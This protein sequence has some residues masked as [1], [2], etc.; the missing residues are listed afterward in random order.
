MIHG[1]HFNNLRGDVCGGLTAAVVAQPLALAFGVVSGAGPVA[2]TLAKLG[3]DRHLPDGHHHVSR[4]DALRQTAA[5]IA[6]NGAP[7]G[8]GDDWTA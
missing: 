5:T 1:I 2:A 8:H 7:A 6:A 3:V 4:L